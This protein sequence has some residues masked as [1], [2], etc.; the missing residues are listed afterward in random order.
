M[1]ANLSQK[2]D[3]KYTLEIVRC[4]W[5]E[6]AIAFIVDAAFYLVLIYQI[7][8]GYYH[9]A[10]LPL[11]CIILM[12]IIIDNMKYKNTV[13]DFVMKSA[14]PVDETEEEGGENGEK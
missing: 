11:C 7:C 2:Y 9:D 12:S 14:T 8:K 6:F 5:W 3:R 10:F 13:F 4:E 1:K